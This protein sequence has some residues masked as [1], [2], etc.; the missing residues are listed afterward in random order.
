MAFSG[1]WHL[2]VPMEINAE[3][4]SDDKK[5]YLLV[6]DR[7]H[8]TTHQHRANH[9]RMTAALWKSYTAVAYLI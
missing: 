7:P 4:K 3:I 5:R 2:Q 9:P 6:A 8:F 1:A